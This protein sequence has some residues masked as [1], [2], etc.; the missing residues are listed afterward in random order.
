V[1]AA[2]N[3]P[4]AEFERTVG[5]TA[6]VIEALRDAAPQAVLVYPSSVSIYGDTGAQAA[7]EMR[8]PNP[9]SAYAK[10]KLTAEELCVAANRAHGL[11]CVIIRFAS[12]YGVGLRKQLLWDLVRML[13][14][15]RKELVLAG[16]GDE[17]RDFLQGEDAARLIALAAQATRSEPLVL[18]G[19]T[20]EARTIRDVA[21]TLS[22]IWGGDRTIRFSGAVNPWDPTHLRIEAG[23]AL[24]LG[25]RPETFSAGLRRYADWARSVL[26]RVDG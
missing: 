13:A 8:A 2:I 25:F 11:G 10:Y 5:T 26:A 7:D 1:R 6:A 24:A 14:E 22:T 9:I 19:A 12:L 17:T 15:G 23:K 3:N 18:N 16:T 4:D 21:N 20:G